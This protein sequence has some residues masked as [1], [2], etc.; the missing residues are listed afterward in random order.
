[1]LFGYLAICFGGGKNHLLFT[2]LGSLK[3]SREIAFAIYL[4]IQA[5]NLM[6]LTSNK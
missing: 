3:T 5:G 1:M 4:A 2:S 6:I